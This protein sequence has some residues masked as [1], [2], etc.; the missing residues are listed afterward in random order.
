MVNWDS[1]AF[2]SAS[3]IC[4]LFV[5]EFGADK[6]IDHTVIVARRTGIPQAIIGLLTAGA[7]WEELAVVIASV[8]RH[9]SSLAIG[10]VVGST[11]SNILGAFSLGL[12]FCSSSNRIVFDRSSKAYSLLLLILTIF[13]TAI[14]YFGRK[15]IWR[16]CSG[17]LVGIFITYVGSVAWVISQGRITSPE[18]SDDDDDSSDEEGETDIR[19]NALDAEAARSNGVSEA[20]SLLQTSQSRVPRRTAH[21]LKYHVFFLFIGFICICLSS[22]VLSHTSS[23]IADEFHVSD[24]LFGVIVISIATTLPEKFIA[25]L[26]GSRGHA[27][28]LVANTVGSNIFYWEFD[29]GSVNTAEL[30]VMLGSTVAL[31]GTVWFGAKWSRWIGGV[32]L[33]SYI[34]FLVLEC[35]VIRKVWED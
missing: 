22:Y 27:G 24:V 31:T 13:V 26:S 33:V 23:A 8:A 25:V 3:F 15:N 1:V 14:A 29:A 28:I 30:G 6:F 32:M 16:I 34:L 7:E 12:L 4:S 11:I 35:T 5:L 17:I 18:L 19:G 21:S 2:N 9:R 20:S 10:N